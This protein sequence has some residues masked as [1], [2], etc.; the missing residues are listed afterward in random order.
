M[1]EGVPLALALAGMVARAVGGAPLIPQAAGQALLVEG[2][3]YVCPFLIAQ[4]RAGDRPQQLPGLAGVH[5]N[6]P[7]VNAFFATASSL[8]KKFFTRLLCFVV[9]SFP[10]YSSTYT[11]QRPVSPSQ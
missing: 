8:S 4:A 3:A 10:V 2:R 9:P 5:Q 11:R 7:F 6:A 1:P